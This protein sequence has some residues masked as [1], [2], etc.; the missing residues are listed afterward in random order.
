[1]TWAGRCGRQRCKLLADA[2]PSS[3]PNAP[4]AGWDVGGVVERDAV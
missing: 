4:V 1:M 2:Q 3:D